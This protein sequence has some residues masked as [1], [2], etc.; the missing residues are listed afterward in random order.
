MTKLLN[1]GIIKSRIDLCCT[2]CEVF[3]ILEFKTCAKFVSVKSTFKKKRNNENKSI[4]RNFNV[5]YE[6]GNVL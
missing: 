6:N 5:F 4:T 3:G 1:D 2:L